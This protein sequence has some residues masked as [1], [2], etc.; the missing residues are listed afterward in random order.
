MSKTDYCVAASAR[1]DGDST[2]S[3]NVNN[4]ATSEEEN[5]SYSFATFGEEESSSSLSSATFRGG[6]VITLVCIALY[7]LIE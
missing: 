5:G 6:A 3:I 2:N 7:A 4:G 1:S